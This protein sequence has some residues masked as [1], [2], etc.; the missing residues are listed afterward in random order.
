MLV[1]LCVNDSYLQRISKQKRQ[2]GLIVEFVVTILYKA[3]LDIW[4]GYKMRQNFD[5]VKGRQKSG[6]K[7]WCPPIVEFVDKHIC[8]RQ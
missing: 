8:N 4:A 7:T 5:D 2:Y 6:I 1:S 3:T